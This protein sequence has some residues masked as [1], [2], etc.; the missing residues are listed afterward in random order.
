MS[1]VFVI[2]IFIFLFFGLATRLLRKF[3]PGF[4][5]K[6][7]GNVNSAFVSKDKKKQKD[8]IY[9]KDDVVIMKGEAKEIKN[10]NKPNNQQI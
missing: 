2:L 4:I 8:I 6:K 9:Q 3:L 5:M 7:M 10:E 1:K